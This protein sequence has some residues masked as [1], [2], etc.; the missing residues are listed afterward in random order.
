ME[1]LS[2]IQLRAI[3]DARGIAYETPATEESSN[4]RVVRTIL[5]RNFPIPQEEAYNTFA[6]PQN[7]VRYFT[8]IK[9]CTPL[10][11]LEGVLE[12][13]QYVVLEHVQEERL[14]PRLMFVKYNLNPPFSISKEAITDPLSDVHTLDRKKGKVSLAFEKLGRN[15]TR[16]VCDSTFTT[17]KGPVFI[18]GFID[19]VW[20]NFF[21]R[22]M[23]ETGE[24]NPSDML[25]KA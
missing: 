10:I 22:V 16:I 5:A 3:A 20:L 12:P 8:I 17:N 6:D 19:H 2:E 24:L 1:A 13:N 25:T 23:I 7:H 21:E 15:S 11:P 14:P 9:A 4:E 18:R